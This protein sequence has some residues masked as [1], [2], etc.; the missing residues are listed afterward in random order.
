MSLSARVTGEKIS[1]VPKPGVIAAS[2][3]PSAVRLSLTE[4]SFFSYRG[5]ASCWYRRHRLKFKI[6]AAGKA[7]PYRS[8][9]G[10]AAG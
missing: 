7:Q 10:R 8:V 9:G 3:L 1:L 6:S 2:P 4:G 5:Y